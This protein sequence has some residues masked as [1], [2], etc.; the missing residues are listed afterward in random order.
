MA[1]HENLTRVPKQQ[2]REIGWTKAR[3]LA[4]VPR[5][6][7]ERFESAPWVH[8]AQALPREEFKRKVERHLTSKETEP[9]RLFISSCTK[10]SYPW[11]KGRSRWQE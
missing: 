5:R 6:D 9:W 10:V 2:L 11:W 4:K 3:E 8:K 7:G 1:I